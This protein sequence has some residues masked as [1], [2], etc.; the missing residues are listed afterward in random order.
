MQPARPRNNRDALEGRNPNSYTGISCEFGRYDRPWAP[1][2]DVY[3]VIRYM[4]SANTVEKLKRKVWLL[5]WGGGACF[6][7]HRGPLGLSKSH[8][9]LDLAACAQPC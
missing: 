5:R 9:A 7:R 6:G 4:S 2:R 3:G 8:I 1:K